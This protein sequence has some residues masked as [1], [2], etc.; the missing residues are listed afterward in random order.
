[1][2]K[3]LFFYLYFSHIYI[4][5]ILKLVS[6]LKTCVCLKVREKLICMFILLLEEK[7]NAA[8]CVA[9]ADGVKWTCWTDGFKFLQPQQV[10]AGTNLNHTVA[11]PSRRAWVEGRAHQ[12]SHPYQDMWGQCEHV[13]ACPCAACRLNKVWVVYLRYW[14]CSSRPEAL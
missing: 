11:E 10:T 12:Q 2:V 14:G 9:R 6:I 5:T 13:S 7:G 4:I 1:M 8:P 3:N